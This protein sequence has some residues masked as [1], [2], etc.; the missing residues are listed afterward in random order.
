MVNEDQQDTGVSEETA[1]AAEEQVAQPEDPVKNLKSEFS[2]KFDGVN[3]TL[4]QL[5]QALQQL[6]VQKQQA[7]A[8]APQ[9]SL[10]EKLYEDPD[11]AAEI[12]VQRATQRADE[13]ISSKMQKQQEMQQRILE[14]T[15]E[16]PEF[17][18][19]GSEASRVATNIHASL[20]ASMR[21]TPEGAELAIQRAALQLGLMPASKRRKPAGSDDGYIPPSTSS[22]RTR[23]EKKENEIKDEQ[24]M[25]AQMLNESIGRTL[26]EKSMKNLKKYA[27]RKQWSK[28]GTGEES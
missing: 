23:S 19:N 18:Q 7:N 27:G 6:T 1:T 11:E 15:A 26:D 21:N 5:N 17:G 8:P 3:N 9:A 14:I 20:P 24:L 12:I 10:K 13:I 28:Y 25:F 4:A 2:R 22:N 16:Y